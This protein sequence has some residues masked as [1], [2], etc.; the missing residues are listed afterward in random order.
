MQVFKPCCSARKCDLSCF[1]FS[2]TVVLAALR[3]K[4]SSRMADPCP[5]ENPLRNFVAHLYGHYRNIH[6]LGNWHYLGPLRRLLDSREMQSYTKSM[7]LAMPVAALPDPNVCCLSQCGGA[8]TCCSTCIIAVSSIGNPRSKTSPMRSNAGSRHAGSSSVLQMCS[9][10][11]RSATGTNGLRHTARLFG[12]VRAAPQGGYR[13]G[14]PWAVTA[15]A[16]NGLTASWR[17]Q[18]LSVAS[19][20]K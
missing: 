16:K 15:D 2:Y 12:D 19:L 13:F 11:G 9:Y 7:L 8:V 20:S 3:R 17:H 5:I 6:L 1:Q 18:G 10:P 14:L 4:S